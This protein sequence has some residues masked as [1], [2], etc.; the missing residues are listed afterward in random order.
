MQRFNSSFLIYEKI[1][2]GNFRSIIYFFFLNLICLYYTR[3]LLLIHYTS[4]L[5]YDLKIQR[6]NETSISTHFPKIS[7]I[8][9]KTFIFFLNTMRRQ[10]YDDS[11]VQLSGFANK[12]EFCFHIFY[13]FPAL[14]AIKTFAFEGEIIMTIFFFLFL[15]L[16]ATGEAAATAR[17]VH[18]LEKKFWRKFFFVY[19]VVFS[20]VTHLALFV[21]VIWHFS[22]MRNDFKVRMKF[23]SFE[24]TVWWQELLLVNSLPMIYVVP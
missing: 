10:K 5:H 15:F 14:S 3:L 17:G 11:R 19:F 16:C 18:E 2:L 7:S 20:S 12:Q 13:I 6:Q 9:T 8:K 1:W 24:S 21:V 4:T 23:S 22:L